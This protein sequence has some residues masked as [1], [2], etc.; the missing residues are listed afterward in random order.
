MLIALLRVLQE[1]QVERVGG[2]RAIPVDVR[3]IAA[4]NR[5]LPAAIALEHSDLICSTGLSVSPSR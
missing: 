4:T 3:V 2:S 5:D 1:R